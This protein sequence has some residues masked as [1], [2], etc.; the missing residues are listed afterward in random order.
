[1]KRY[2]VL[3]GA[4]LVTTG[5]SAQ[6]SCN[7]RIQIDTEE[8]VFKITEE[9][10][11]EFMLAPKNSVFIYFSLMKQDEYASLVMQV[12][13]NAVEMPP[14]MC[15]DSRSRVTFKL[16]DDSYVALPYLDDVNCGE[17]TDHTDRLDNSTS[18]AA[19]FID[20][21]A[22]EKLQQSEIVSMRLT[23]MKTNF[24]VEFQK[25]ISNQDIP[26]PIYPREYFINTL[27]C[28]E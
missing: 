26:V 28:V 16:A 7:Y 5:L 14:I 12:S 24:D 22:M 17:Q 8:E 23:S 25:V 6:N 13:V 3:L 10:L 20:E 9:K 19:F 11:V 1:M 2:I 27:H 15:F 21:S 18:E 4:I